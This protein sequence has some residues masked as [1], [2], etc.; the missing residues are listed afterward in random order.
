MADYTGGPHLLK[1]VNSSLV[2]E[3]LENLGSATRGE[4]ADKTGLSQPTVNTIVKQ[5]LKAGVLT[6]DGQAKSSGGRK[7]QIFTI[8][9]DHT[10]VLAICLYPSHFHYAKLNAAGSIMDTENVEYTGI[11]PLPEGLFNVVDKLLTHQTGIKGITVGMPGAVSR[12]GMAFAI[13]QIPELEN[14][15]LK[16]MLSER[17]NLPV[18]LENDLNCMALGYYAQ[19]LIG[20]SDNLVHIHVGDVIGAGIVV[21]K[22]ILRGHSSF[23]GEISYIFSGE[24]GVNR[25]GEK[26]SFK[27][28]YLAAITN[29]KRASLIAELATSV[30]CIL[31]PPTIVF[32][33]GGVDESLLEAAGRLCE[34]KLPAA[35]IPEFA[36]MEDTEHCYTMG[37]LKLV[38]DTLDMNVRIISRN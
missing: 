10:C 1:Q 12:S 31:N 37:L 38:Q 17:Y 8:D 2:L 21:N 33:G 26:D 34:K 22:E 35:A 19:G 28:E 3:V 20:K 27:K 25:Y 18:V 14:V 36:M 13:P 30:I 6:E 29:A 5:L 9:P 7:A 32:S 15:P 16:S 11:N 4:L 23:A 24:P